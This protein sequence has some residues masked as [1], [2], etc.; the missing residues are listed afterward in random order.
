VL[1]VA[2]IGEESTSLYASYKRAAS[3][4][5]SYSVKCALTPLI[6]RGT[7]LYKLHNFLLGCNVYFNI[8]KKHV[9]YRR[10]VIATLYI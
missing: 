6:Y 3:T 9:V 8:I 7:S 2:I 5:Y 1:S 10:I 4:K